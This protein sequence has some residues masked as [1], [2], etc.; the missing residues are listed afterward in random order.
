MNPLYMECEKVFHSRK[1]TSLWYY[2]C[3]VVT[4]E[5]NYTPTKFLSMDI[6]ADYVK[7]FADIT[8][9]EAMF[10]AGDFMQGIRPHYE[11]L[12]V[13]ITKRP[14]KLNKL[15]VEVQYQKF[16]GILQEL[17]PETSIDGRPEV[18]Q[19][20]LANHSQFIKVSI[21]L[22]D[23]TVEDL[24]NESVGTIIYH[25][26]PASALAAFLPTLTTD[27]L[28]F[29]MQP[30]DNTQAQAQIVIPP[31]PI[32]DLADHMQV[33]GGGIY[34]ADIGCYLQNQ[35]W[36]VWSLYDTDPP[37]YIDTTVTFILAPKDKYTGV[38]NTYRTT[39][40][41]TIIVIVGD[42]VHLDNSHIARYN[43]GGGIRF[44]DAGKLLDDLVRM[45]GP[46]PLL[47]RNKN[48]TEIL[49]HPNP[50]GKNRVRTVSI[51]NNIY[52]EL[53]KVAIQ[54]GS[55]LTVMWD[56][57]DPS[58]L[59]PDSIVKVMVP[60][61][62]GVEEFKARILGAQ[63]YIRNTGQGVLAN[64]FV[65]STNVLLFVESDFGKVTPDEE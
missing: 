23:P 47:A 30:P 40:R 16:R 32:T 26:T 62:G 12:T 21:E 9:I 36:Y 38:E 28:S 43:Q 13:I 3:I 60:V 46:T 57:S 2:E 55:Y 64:R 24:R 31:M 29:D 33:D 51:K 34:K 56:H 48:A 35:R 50:T 19:R 22:Q 8:A 52:D 54:R 18:D 41:Q 17:T 14:D 65:T 7:N 49:H 20:E 1:D 44:T 61:G 37:D 11:N 5:A 15:E 6:N 58:L 4:P 25:Q 27:V 53:S 63:T 39:T 59:R 45:D 42:R 10:P